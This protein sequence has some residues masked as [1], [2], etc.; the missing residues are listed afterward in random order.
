M[1]YSL[2]SLRAGW[3]GNVCCRLSGRDR[4]IR[5][6]LYAAVLEVTPEKLGKGHCAT[7]HRSVT[8]DLI[9]T[10]RAVPVSSIILSALDPLGEIPGRG[11]TG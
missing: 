11:D 1:A 3:A 10:V 9:A 4:F 7:R 5:V 2:G 8:R 6:N